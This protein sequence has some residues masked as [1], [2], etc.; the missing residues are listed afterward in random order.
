MPTFKVILLALFVFASVFWMPT[1]PVEAHGADSVVQI[2][3]APAGEYL[4]TIITSPATLRVGAVHF[5]VMVLDRQHNRPLPDK[6]VRV[7]V[8]PLETAGGIVSSWA[9][10]STTLL[11]AYETHLVLSKAGRYQVKVMVVDANHPVHPVSFE[12]VARSV[13]VFQWLILLLFA[14][15]FLVAGWLLQ[16]GLT[17]WR[18]HVP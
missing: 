16:E 3:R 12:V 15:A 13:V 7:E 8:T 17:V 5:A 4:L 11:F 18:R 2:D 6:K 1:H 10:P 14:Q 9:A